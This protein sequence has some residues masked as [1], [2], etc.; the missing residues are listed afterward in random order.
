MLD[1]GIL[2]GPASSTK[3]ALEDS[4]WLSSPTKRHLL[5]YELK[6]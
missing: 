4:L 5:D 3:M 1:G 6:G 2:S